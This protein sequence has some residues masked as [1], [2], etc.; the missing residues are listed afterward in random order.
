MSILLDVLFLTV[1]LSHFGV[2][3]LNGSKGV[4]LVY[5]SGSLGLSNT[6]LG[7]L[8]TAYTVL[9]S[10]MQPVFG[11]VTDRVGPRWVVAGG[12]LWIGT[13]FSLAAITPGVG[14]LFFLVAGSLG[15]GAFHP[16]GTMQATLVGRS[17]FAGRETTSTSYFFMLGQV[18]LFLGPLLGGLL[19]GSLGPQGWLILTAPAFLMAFGAGIRLP[20]HK[21][22][23]VARPGH[24]ETSGRKVLHTSLWILLALA[25]MTAFRAMVQ[26]NMN[27]FLPKYLSDLGY[28]PEVY[29]AIAALFMGGSALGNVLGG[30][31]ADRF[32]KRRVAVL[33]LTLTSLPLAL[34]PAIRDLS[35]LY[36]LIPLAGAFSGASHSIIVVFAQRIIPGGMA[37]ASGLILG[38]MF[39]TGALGTLLSGY[40]ADLWGVS[41]VFTFSAGLALA[42]AAMTGVL[43][44]SKTAN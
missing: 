38:F 42:A 26:Q 18:G 29:G 10:L 19:L 20:A 5:L 22:V 39:S 32:G 11:Y 6:A 8:S 43:R 15:S 4:L 13:C 41:I 33:T 27:T 9:G 7:A 14:A 2:D 12:L 36:L 37:T 24:Q 23:M 30:N 1:S 17:R 40:L 28:A 31:L 21:P 25:L 35:W 16:A 44:D 34:L 3:V